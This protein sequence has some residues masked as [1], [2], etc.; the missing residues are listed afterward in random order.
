MKLSKKPSETKRV[1]T[2]ALEKS[3]A[4]RRIQEHPESYSTSNPYGEHLSN[5]AI[6]VFKNGV[7]LSVTKDNTQLAKFIPYESLTPG[8]FIANGKKEDSE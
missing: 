1:T 4:L 5:I 8:E 7:Y 2:S 6:D 3:G